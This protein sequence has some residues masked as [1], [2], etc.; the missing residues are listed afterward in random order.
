MADLSIAAERF[1]TLATTVTQGWEVLSE[2]W[3][4]SDAEQFRQTHLTDTVALLS[5]LA[6]ELSRVED[7]CREARQE[8]TEE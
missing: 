5:R 4:D 1:A 7:V 3:Q 2:T 8:L 6:E